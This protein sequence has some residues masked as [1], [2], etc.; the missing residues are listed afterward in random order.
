MTTEQFNEFIEEIIPQQLFHVEPTDMDGESGRKLDEVILV[1][2]IDNNLGCL[3]HKPLQW[4][5]DTFLIENDMETEF[6]E[7]MDEKFGKHL[8]GQIEDQMK[9]ELKE[10]RYLEI[11]NELLEE[12]KKQLRA[13]LEQQFL[14][15]DMIGS[16][17]FFS[18]GG[19]EGDWFRE[20]EEENRSLN[21]MIDSW[22]DGGCSTGL[23]DD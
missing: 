14:Q 18:T 13:E 6:T 11:E 23:N 20:I 5:L 4:F 17:D 15:G 19:D 12:S 3:S 2:L 9:A 22:D 1:R 10:Q 8:Q 16:D 21:E 7:E